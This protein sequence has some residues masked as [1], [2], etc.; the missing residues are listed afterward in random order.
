ME[1]KVYF[2]KHG[3]C[4]RMISFILVFAMLATMVVVAP[5]SATVVKAAEGVKNVS[6]HFI[7]PEGWN[8]TTPAIQYWGGSSTEVS[9]EVS[10]PT[11]I[12]GWGG[13]QG[14]VLTSNGNNDFSISLKGDFEGFQFWD[15]SNPNNNTGGKGYESEMAEC[16]ADTAMD[17]YYIYTADKNG[18]VWYLDAAGT[19]PLKQ[20]KTGE[21]TK[22]MLTLN[23]KNKDSWNEVAAY[24]YAGSNNPAGAWPGIKLNGSASQDGWM[25]AHLLVDNSDNYKCIFNNGGNGVQ[26]ADVEVVTKAQ[27]EAEYWWD[28]T[29]FTAEKP[30][31]WKYTTTL[32]YLAN[33]WTGVNAHMWDGGDAITGAWPGLAATANKD[34]E[35]WFDVSCT[36]GTDA[37]FTCIFNNGNGSQ[38]D[39]VEVKVT[40]TS[41]ELWV[42]GTKGDVKVYQEAPDTWEAAPEEYT[43]KLYYYNPDMTDYSN[44]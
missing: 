9:G 20:E 43:F 22:C 40:S 36:R 41:T 33:G 30:E 3:I 29:T 10:G 6:L 42:T 16:T 13:A 32:H 24:L 5:G 12:T 31:G 35:G 8:W 27:T 19:T 38:T 28:G 4:K 15:M 39:D 23:F 7:L 34:H 18:L 26:N 17:L 37:D 2:K 1:K 21:N 25:T 14:Y 44:R 11:E